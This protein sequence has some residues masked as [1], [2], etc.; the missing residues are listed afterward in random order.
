MAGGILR[1]FVNGPPGAI[2]TSRKVI[3]MTQN[4]TTSIEANRRRMKAT[5][6]D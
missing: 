4:S 1:S 2:R 6:D 5:I 3:V